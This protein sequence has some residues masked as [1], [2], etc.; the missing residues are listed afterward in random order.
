M[1]TSFYVKSLPLIPNRAS[2]SRT[3]IRS[4]WERSKNI[5]EKIYL[6]G[7]TIRCIHSRH[8]SLTIW[9]SYMKVWKELRKAPFTLSLRN[10]LKLTNSIKKEVFRC[11]GQNAS[12]F[13]VKRRSVFLIRRGVFWIDRILLEISGLWTWSC[14]IVNFVVVWQMWQTVAG[15]LPRFSADIEPFTLLLQMWQ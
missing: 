15:H 13:E 5:W 12:V 11:L 6:T 14:Q 9:K 4:I 10:L 1:K 2:G 3:K 8:H 7:N